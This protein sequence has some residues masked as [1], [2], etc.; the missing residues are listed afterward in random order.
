MTAAS[1][2]LPPPTSSPEALTASSDAGTAATT[3]IVGSGGRPRAV[4]T[5]VLQRDLD[6]PPST[7]VESLPPAIAVAEEETMATTGATRSRSKTQPDAVLYASRERGESDVSLPAAKETLQVDSVSRSRANS[8]A[9]QSGTTTRPVATRNRAE[10]Q[11]SVVTTT[12]TATTI[13][14][15]GGEE[16]PGDCVPT[17][18]VKEWKK[19]FEGNMKEGEELVCSESAPLP[20]LRF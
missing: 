8:N 4:T 18:R 12:T 5:P 3:T 6:L 13:A 19:H 17:K 9:S 11:A 10:S 20:R 14:G 16:G 1:S 15:E 2:T 7:T